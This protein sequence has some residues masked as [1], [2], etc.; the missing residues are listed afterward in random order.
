[1]LGSNRLKYVR[2]GAGGATQNTKYDPYSST[3]CYAVMNSVCLQY[4][5][6]H[7]R[8]TLLDIALYLM[9]LIAGHTYIRNVLH[10]QSSKYH[11]ICECHE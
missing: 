8:Y 2:V 4:K 7:V 9:T 6:R 5:L 3:L 11:C 1:M 10:T